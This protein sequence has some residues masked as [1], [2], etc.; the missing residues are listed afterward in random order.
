MW[1]KIDLQDLIKERQTGIIVSL[2]KAN[3]KKFLL[4][5]I[6]IKLLLNQ[7]LTMGIRIESY[8]RLF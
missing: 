3:T 1:L 7:N 8:H 2:K 4:N 6:M 5:L